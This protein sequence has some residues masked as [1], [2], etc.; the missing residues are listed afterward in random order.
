MGKNLYR[1]HVWLM[2]IYYGPAHVLHA[3]KVQGTLLWI[4]LNLGKLSAI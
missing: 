2:K 3:E 1:F 4:A